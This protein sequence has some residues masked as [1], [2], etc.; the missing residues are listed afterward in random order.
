MVSKEK[1]TS[2]MKPHQV[3]K[4]FQLAADQSIKVVTNFVIDTYTLKQLYN[5]TPIVSHTIHIAST[6]I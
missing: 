4:P 1:N 6:G 3:Q 2:K 5:S